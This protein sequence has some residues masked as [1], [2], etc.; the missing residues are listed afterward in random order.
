MDAFVEKNDDNT[1]PKI[2][3]FY[4]GS[5]EAVEEFGRNF[6][7]ETLGRCFTGVKK[8]K[9]AFDLLLAASLY[10]FFR[11]MSK[12]LSIWTD[13]DILEKIE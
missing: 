6:N 5:N 4:F 12:I 11:N 10:P 1:R 3:L 7:E 8:C 13:R 2:M 9:F